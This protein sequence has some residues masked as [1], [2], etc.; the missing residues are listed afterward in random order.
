MLLLILKLG[1]HHFENGFG[2]RRVCHLLHPRAHSGRSSRP[3]RALSRSN[4][5]HSAQS[6]KVR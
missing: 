6:F 2:K 5:Q 1:A 4:T 3:A